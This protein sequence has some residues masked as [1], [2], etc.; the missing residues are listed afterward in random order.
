MNKLKKSVLTLVTVFIAFLLVACGN[1]G[2]SEGQDALEAI[3]DR[4][5][6]N[7]GTSPDYP[8]MEF[9]ILDENDDRQIVGSDI[10]LAQAIADEIGVD[11]NITTT[12]FDGVIANV[13]SGSVDM[14]IS[15]FTFTERRA[16]V[17]QFSEGYLQESDLGFQGIMMH[18]Q[19]AEQFDSLEEIEEAELVLGAQGGS[20]QQEL[21]NNLTDP[22]NVKQYGTLDVGLAALN[23]GDIDGMVVAT[24]SAEPM[25]L[26]FPNLVILPQEEFDLDPDRLY[27]TNA[28]ALPLGEEYA[29]LLEVVNQVIQ[30]NKEN[31][32]I[33]KWHA[34]A[35]ELSRE[36]IE[37]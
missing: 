33:A 19:I 31:G 35:V 1:S 22:S 26:T 30:E 8:P 37:E 23:E 6:L 25:L 9:Y 13:Q 17:M 4:G 36:A 21:A 12:D 29:S 14:G 16:E 15:G 5:E 7:V 10:D 2:T 32:N 27:S 3:K 11:L 18:E 34:D 28:V 24:S 20:I